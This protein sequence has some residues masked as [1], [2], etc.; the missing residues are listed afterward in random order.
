MNFWKAMRL[1]TG[2]T[3]RMEW[4][5]MLVTLIFSVYMGVMMS[6]IVGELY[7]EEELGN[8]P[9]FID[10]VYLSILPA[11]GAA[12]SRTAMSVWRSD[13]FT[14]K[15]AFLR[16]YP[17]PASAIVGTR[18]AQTVIMLLVNIP[19]FQSITYAL[20]PEL[21]E[22]V[23]IGNWIEVSML[24]LCYSLISNLFFIWLEIG[25]SG[26]VYIAGYSIWFV[27]IS[28]AAFAS[29]MLGI[30]EQAFG[31]AISWTASDTSSLIVPC[32]LICSV[33]ATWIGYRRIARRF[34]SRSMK[35]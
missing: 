29:A 18:I 35:F 12:M 9:Y 22:A 2:H 1:L 6:I 4:L 14:K 3:L 30:E 19:I 23:S 27:L 17:I 24:F 11:Y 10:W 16:V 26:K 32:V 20:S 34:V 33:L 7:R 8:V 25:H 15:L 28:I 13:A 21:R 31:S 5:G